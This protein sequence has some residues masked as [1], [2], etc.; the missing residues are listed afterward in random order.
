MSSTI[1]T[2]RLTAAE[3]IPILGQGTW[4]MGEKPV[5]H[6]DEGAAL[7]LGLDLGMSLIDTA[8]LYGDGGAEDCAIS[9]TSAISSVDRKS[10]AILPRG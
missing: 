10:D 1:R 8:E 3:D 7:R 6:A 4:G 2:T 5:R 9:R